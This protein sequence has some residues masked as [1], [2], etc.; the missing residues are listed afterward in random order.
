MAK[1]ISIRDIGKELGISIT[2]VSFVLNGKAKEKRI[3]ET[4]TKK[5]LD[6]VEKVNFKP[7]LM[8]QGLRT[9][10]SKI[11]CLMVED[12][13]KNALFAQVARYIEE[14]AHNNG[15]R[16]IYCSTGNKKEKASEL[17]QLFQDRCIDGYIITPPEGIEAD[18]TGLIQANIPVVLIDRLLPGITCN[19]VIVD[20]FD[21]AYQGTIHLIENGCQNIAVI[22]SNSS[23][24]QMQERLSGYRHALSSCNLSEHIQMLSFYDSDEDNINLILKFIKNN[25]TIDGLFFTTNYIGSWGL[26]ALKRLNM[27]IPQQIRV[28]SFDDTD[29]FRFYTPAI[30]V[31]AQPILE[32]SNQIMSIL[33]KDLAQDDQPIQQ[34]VLPT[35]LIIRESSI[36]TQHPEH[37][38]E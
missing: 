2:T 33:L 18:I 12:I 8:A 17:L 27:Q 38:R 6:F 7:N 13:S 14:A 35:K 5:I 23:Q 28:V 29:L 36:S 24:N 25:P 21:G 3:S 26:Q 22:T 31:I 9:G 11:L 20:N 34:V 30:T 1:K 37:L 10:K 32:I 15:Y 19:H 16:I 4:L